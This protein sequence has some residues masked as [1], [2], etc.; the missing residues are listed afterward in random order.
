MLKVEKVD[1]N[2][3][4][5]VIGFLKSNIVRHVFAFHDTQHEPEHTT[6]YAAFK[7]EDLRGYILIYTV[8]EF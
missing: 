4:Q 1:E 8:L 6:V 3:K 7:D 2:N 5:R